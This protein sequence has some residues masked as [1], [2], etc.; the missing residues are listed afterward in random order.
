LWHAL[1]HSQGA[2][3]DAVFYIQKGKVT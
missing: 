2:G 1:G 3:C